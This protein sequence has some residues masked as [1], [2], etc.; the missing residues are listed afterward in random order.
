[1]V[2]YFIIL[3]EFYNDKFY[4]IK[5]YDEKISNYTDYLVGDRQNQRAIENIKNQINDIFKIKD[6]KGFLLLKNISN[7]ELMNIKGDENPK[8]LFQFI[9]FFT[10]KIY[11]IFTMDLS[12]ISYYDQ[13]E[14]KCNEILINFCKYLFEHIGELAME[15]GERKEMN[16]YNLNKLFEMAEILL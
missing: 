13:F 11:A 7:S 1:M 6:K 12:D 2:L 3:Y 9:N 4:E 5:N 14:Y 16:D 10:P 8:R 15:P